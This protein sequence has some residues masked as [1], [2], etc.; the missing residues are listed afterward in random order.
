MTGEEMERALEFL[1]K[2]QA[3]TNEQLDQLTAQVAET[4]R[5]MQI[6]AETQSQFIEI[7]TV[8]MNRLAE[9][10]AR[11]AEQIAQISGHA[12]ETDARLDRLATMIELHVTNGHGQT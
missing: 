5:I 11:T 8:T 2:S 6:Q 1:A 10:Q 3:D 7:V 9:A 4:N 12:N